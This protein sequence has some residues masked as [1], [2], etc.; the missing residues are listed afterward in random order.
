MNKNRLAVI[1]SL[2]KNDSVD[3]VNQSVNSIL[4]QSFKDFNFYIQFDGI[5]NQDVDDYINSINDD[6]LIIRKR[7][8]NKGLAISLNELLNE[9]LPLGYEYIARMDSDD[10]ALLDRFQKQIDYLDQHK[11]VDI[12]GGAINEIDELGNNRNK[13]INYPLSHE[14]C[15]SFFAKR[16]PIVHPAVMFRKSFFTKTGCLYPTE[17]DRNEDTALWMEGFKHGA[18]MANMPDVILN[19]RITQALFKHRR[20]GRDFA[21]SQLKLRKKINKELDYGMISYICAYAMYILMISPPC[22]I[23]LAYK[24]LR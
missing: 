13:I 11:E 24:V 9:V 5:V 8:V 7:S 17:Y 6:R 16:N 20:R 2:Y 23:K 22:L 18:I 4:K 12:L 14:E 15:R 10:I 21:G 3:Y 19:L 1:M